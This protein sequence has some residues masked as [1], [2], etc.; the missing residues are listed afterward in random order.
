[1]QGTEA[2]RQLWQSLLASGYRNAA[3]ELDE[4][5]HWGDVAP[6]IGR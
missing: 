1:V 3:L 2:V 6:A 5:E 4:I